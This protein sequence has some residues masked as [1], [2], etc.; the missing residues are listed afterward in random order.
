MT[1]SG[2]DLSESDTFITDAKNTA[3]FGNET[4]IKNMK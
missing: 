2:K 3:N 4:I 1:C